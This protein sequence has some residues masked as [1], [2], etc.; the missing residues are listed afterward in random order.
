MYTQRRS[1]CR[2]EAQYLLM[3]LKRGSPESC[4]CGCP[5]AGGPRLVICSQGLASLL[6]QGSHLLLQLSG[7][8]RAAW[9]AS[10]PKHPQARAG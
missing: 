1:A 5:A 3:V 6:S 8:R 10:C 7:H 2:R 4:G 9:P